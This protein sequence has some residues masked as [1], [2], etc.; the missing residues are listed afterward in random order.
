MCLGYDSLVFQAFPRLCLTWPRAAVLTLALAPPAW[1][2]PAAEEPA[3]APAQPAPESAVDPASPRAAVQASLD[4]CRD[5]R[6]EEAAAFLDLSGRP[7][8][9]GAALARRLKA[10]LDRHLWI[11]LGAVSPA[12]RGDEGDRL[13]P[14]VDELGTI[15][16]PSGE[17]E[18][19]RL[20]RRV[21]AEGPRWVF[22]RD[23]VAEVERWY[24]ELGDRWLRE[25]LPAALFLPGPR[26]LLWWQW[27]AL[28][29]LLT[30]AVFVGRGLGWATRRLIV[31][32]T[33]RT[34]ARWDDELVSR[35]GGMLSFVW[36]LV[37][38]YA[39][40]PSLGLYAPAAAFWA[41]LRLVD[42]A[43]A[44][45]GRTP[46]VAASASVRSLLVIGGRAAK[47]LVLAMGAI[48][49]L[50]ELGYPVASLLAGLGLGG[51]AVALAAQKTV[52]NLFGSVS[53]AVDQPFRVGDFVRI[54]DFV[55]TVEAIGLRST[56]IRTLDRTLVTLPNGRLSDM[57]LE[58]FSARDRL[59]LAC[60]VGLVYGT[61]A[62][63]MREVLAG[64]E[65]VLRAHP[66]IW[67]DAVIVR[68]KEFAASSL[69]IEVMAWF[70]TP[71]WPEFQLY[72]QEVLLQFMEIVE[73]AGTSFAFPTRTVH[74]VDER[75]AET[76]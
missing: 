15:P 42:V 54:E 11:D 49:A 26:E 9:D 4:L 75:P 29:T 53:L 52:E 3:A 51:L 66:H 14:G 10:V 43:A 71:V 19:V 48:A 30:G 67:P 17:P 39:V 37:V 76:P 63:Q 62:E 68:F 46:W 57:R 45:L 65:R 8:A 33:S 1:A 73:R 56:R 34:A 70:D 32:I 6:Y 41:L 22:S 50:S 31:R 35:L 24:R 38:V 21:G 55:G 40:V 25:R 61:T 2:A 59:R 13:P 47:A 28:L 7:R 20:V 36:T 16:S 69:D 27:I 64:L 23:T 5:G 12:A 74:L 44:A 18:P 58:S 60:N 72:R